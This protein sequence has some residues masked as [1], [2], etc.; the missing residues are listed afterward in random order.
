M[1]VLVTGGAGFAGRYAVAE[2][3]AHGHRVS[4]L[5]LPGAAAVEGVEA[6]YAAD[7]SSA[8]DVARA[9]V[10]C[11]P[12]A[13]LHLAGMAFVPEGDANPGGVLRANLHGTLHVL[14]SL[15]A[16]GKPV[17]ALVVSTSQVYGASDVPIDEDAP[18]VP[19]SLYAVSKAAADLLALSFYRQYGQDVIVAR[20]TNH[21]GPGQSPRFAIPAFAAQVRRAKTQK[22][23][24]IRVGNLESERIILDVRDVVRA[25]RLLLE[26]GAAG[27]VYNIC[28]PQRLSMRVILDRL[29]ALAGV[30]AE[31]E[32]EAARFRPTDHAVLA[33]VSRLR[34]ATGW[35]AEIPL[36]RTLADVLN[37]TRELGVTA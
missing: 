15:R 17:R 6:C 36:D 34:A 1:H 24:V 10:E 26:S 14:E 28:G 3:A 31:Y 33:D 21:T 32:V 8:A 19:S 9:V 13:C 16:L 29:C 12:D 18:L 5:D 23:P 22:C 25:Y 37:A 2:L 11:R 4:V 27:Q 20:P 35:Q 30:R 7:V